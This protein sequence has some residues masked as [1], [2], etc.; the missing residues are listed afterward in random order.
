MELITTFQEFGLSGA[1]IGALFYQNIQVMRELRSMNEQADKRICEQSDRHNEERK[2]WRLALNRLSDALD[3][4]YDKP[5][6]TADR[7]RSSDI[8]VDRRQ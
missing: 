6:Q 8:T 5:C 3:K 4:L 1:V 2:E 7:R